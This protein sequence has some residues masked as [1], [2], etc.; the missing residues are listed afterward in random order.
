M[1]CWAV[2]WCTTKSKKEI[3]TCNKYCVTHTINLVIL[4]MCKIIKVYY[5]LKSVFF[6][7]TLFF[8]GY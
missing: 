1:L 4:D 7:T 5:R 6:L 3:S 8:I 2:W